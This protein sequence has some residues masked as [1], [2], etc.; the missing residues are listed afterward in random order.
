MTTRIAIARTKE[1]VLD[2]IRQED[3]HQPLSNRAIRDHLQDFG[4]VVSHEYVRGLLHSFGVPNVYE[5]RTSK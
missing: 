3:A 2:L 4:I 1:H 5:R